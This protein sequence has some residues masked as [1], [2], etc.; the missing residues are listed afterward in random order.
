MPE[1]NLYLHNLPLEEAI[2]KY[3]A[4]LEGMLAP[5]Y[6]E[7]AVEDSLDRITSAA[8]FA[9]CS[10]PPFN[11]A[12]MDGIAVIAASTAGASETRPLSLIPHDACMPGE[13]SS[14]HS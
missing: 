6:E 7:I 9:R 5:R 14:D 8:V 2:Q 10:S 12:A 11:A 4:A 13:S 3:C 1:R